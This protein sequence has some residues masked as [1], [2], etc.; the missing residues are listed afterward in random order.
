MSTVRTVATRAARWVSLVDAQV[1]LDAA[2]ASQALEALQGLYFDLITTGA[3]LTDVLKAVNYTANENERITNS[4]SITVT[5]PTSITDADTSTL[6]PPRDFSTVVVVGSTPATYVY[7]ANLAA[8]VHIEGLTLD[9][10]APWSAFLGQS[11]AA[12]LAVF[13]GEEGG[14]AIPPACVSIAT[15]G[16]TRIIA[17]LSMSGQNNGSLFLQPDMTRSA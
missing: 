2:I 3:D 17:R 5:L 4:A 14:I 11:L 9:S 16:R 13:M 15:A 10:E 12:M 6:R 1:P 8:W 7:D